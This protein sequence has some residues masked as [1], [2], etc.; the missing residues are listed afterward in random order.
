MCNSFKTELLGGTT[1][2]STLTITGNNTFANTTNTYKATGATTINFG[3]TTQ[4]VGN[5]TAAG[6]VGRMLTL[7]GSSASSPCTLVH[8]GSGTAADVN[9]LTIT[10]VRAF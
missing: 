3:T 6:E 5:F 2:I 4:R 8:T 9:Y 1:G 7:T 10:G